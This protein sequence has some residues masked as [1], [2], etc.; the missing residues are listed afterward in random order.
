MKVNANEW[1]DLV[2]GTMER[3]YRK[4]Q[5]IDRGKSRRQGGGESQSPGEG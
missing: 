5:M 2:G 3:S 4:E 1:N